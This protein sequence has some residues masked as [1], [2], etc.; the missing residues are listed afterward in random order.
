[1]VVSGAPVPYVFT[2]VDK[3]LRVQERNIRLM[4]DEIGA[5]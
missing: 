3:D 5:E 2:E 1:M 4:L